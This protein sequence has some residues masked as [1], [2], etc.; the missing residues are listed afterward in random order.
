MMQL[1]AFIA[2]RLSAV[3][4]VGFVP[5]ISTSSKPV[6]PAGRLNGKSSMAVSNN[7]NPVLGSSQPS[8]L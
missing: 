7:S 3:G 6:N 5:T 8:I 4:V 1:V 2:A